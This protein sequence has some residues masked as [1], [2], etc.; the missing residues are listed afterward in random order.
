MANLL[1]R[2]VFQKGA[3]LKWKL[4]SKSQRYNLRGATEKP[5]SG[6]QGL[7]ARYRFHTYSCPKYIWLIRLCAEVDMGARTCKITWHCLTCLEIPSTDHI[8]LGMRP[9]LIPPASKCLCN[10]ANFP[11]TLLCP[12]NSFPKD[13]HEPYTS[14]PPVDST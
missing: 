12:L 14:E 6:A 1:L 11:S 10:H 4:A 5:Y 2:I 7:T 3:L 8:G 13:F 9:L